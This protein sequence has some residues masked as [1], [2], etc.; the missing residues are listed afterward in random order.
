MDIANKRVLITGGSSG[1]GLALAR[2]LGKLGA[3]VLLAARQEEGLRTAKSLLAGEGVDVAAVAADV[4][5]TRGRAVMLEVA[6]LKLGGIDRLAR[7]TSP[8][9]GC[10]KGVHRSP[11]NRGSGAPSLPSWNN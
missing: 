6:R 2:A 3:R 7:Q 1:I 5:R 9:R 4:T 11:W 10:R 8:F